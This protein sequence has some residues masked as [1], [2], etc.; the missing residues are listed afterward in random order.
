LPAYKMPKCG[1]TYIVLYGLATGD[2]NTNYI[3]S[4]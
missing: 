2:S 3:R 4:T 1:A